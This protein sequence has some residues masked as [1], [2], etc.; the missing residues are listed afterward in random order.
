MKYDKDKHN[1]RLIH[2][3]E[4]NLQEREQLT[5]IGFRRDGKNVSF[6]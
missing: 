4:T 6:L 2:C 1:Y 3:S 5:F